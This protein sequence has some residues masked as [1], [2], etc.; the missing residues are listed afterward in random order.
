MIAMYEMLRHLIKK[1]KKTNKK[2]SFF[3]FR[4]WIFDFCPFVMTKRKINLCILPVSRLIISENKQSRKPKSRHW[5]DYI[6]WSR[7]FA[8][9]VCWYTCA[10]HLYLIENT[11]AAALGLFCWPEG[12]EKQTKKTRTLF[13]CF[14]S[15]YFYVLRT[16]PPLVFI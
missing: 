7:L 13:L 15:I 1:K 12:N 2:N 10:L 9:V 4:F 3:D 16:L 8:V 11:Q 14:L 6:L 5:C